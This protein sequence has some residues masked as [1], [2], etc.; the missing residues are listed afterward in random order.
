MY[1]LCCWFGDRAL[2]TIEEY[3]KW[4]I[5]WHISKQ[6]I[7]QSSVIKATTDGELVSPEKTQDVKTQGTGPRQLS[8]ISKEWFQW[9]RLL[10]LSI[11][12]KPTKFLNLGYLAFYIQTICPLLQNFYITCLLWA[13]LLGLLEMLPPGLEATKVP[14]Q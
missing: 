14:A 8:C 5:P 13:V 9:A 10:H 4:N 1:C 6:R 12:E 3:E 11:H 7:S 2:R